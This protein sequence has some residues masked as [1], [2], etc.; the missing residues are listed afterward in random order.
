MKKMKSRICVNIVQAKLKSS[1][2]W[3]TLPTELHNGLLRVNAGTKETV[4]ALPIKLLKPRTHAP[5]YAK[6]HL[7]LYKTSRDHVKLSGKNQRQSYSKW[8]GAWQNQQN[9]LCAKRR[10]IS[11][12]IRPVWSVFA[13]RMKKHWALNYLLSAQWRLWSDRADAQADLSLRW[14]HLSFCWFCCAWAQIE[15]VTMLCSILQSDLNVS[16]DQINLFSQKMTLRAQI[17]LQETSYTM[18]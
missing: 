13:V 10:Q 12:G 6:R 4:K 18:K 8:A 1:T 14:A 9:D 5:G 2:S 11:L 17:A 7:S 16:K 15:C 3:N